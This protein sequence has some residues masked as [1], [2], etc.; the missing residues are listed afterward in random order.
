MSCR[1]FFPLLFS[2]WLGGLFFPSGQRMRRGSSNPAF[3]EG[4]KIGLALVTEAKA[5]EQLA[6][7]PFG[8]PSELPPASAIQASSALLQLPLM[9]RILLPPGRVGD[10]APIAQQIAVPVLAPADAAILGLEA[11]N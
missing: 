1:T 11:A 6:L 2:H 3:L 9:S 7:C 10:R 8:L 4:S 5:L